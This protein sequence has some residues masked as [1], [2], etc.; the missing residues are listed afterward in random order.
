MIDSSFHPHHHR[1]HQTS[2]CHLSLGSL[3][4]FSNKTLGSLHVP[5]NLSYR[6]GRIM[7]VPCLKCITYLGQIPQT[8]RTWILGHLISGSSSSCCCHTSL[9]SVS[10]VCKHFP[11]T[12][13]VPTVLILWASLISC[14]HPPTSVFIFLPQHLPQCSI[15]YLFAWLFI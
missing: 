7:S 10:G 9:L 13:P 3:D 6:A 5:S 14:P 12:W 4:T 2:S 8:L 15:S 11:H 1:H